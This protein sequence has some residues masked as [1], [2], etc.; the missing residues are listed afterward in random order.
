MGRELRRI[1]LGWDFPIGQTWTGY[2]N[3]HDGERKKCPRCAGS[4]ESVAMRLL[5]M[6]WYRHRHDEARA[7][8]VSALAGPYNLPRPL[9]RFVAGELEAGVGWSRRLDQRDV[10]ALAA[11]ERLWD[12][13]R[14]PRTEGQREV[15]REK[16][17]AG[18]NS[19]LPESNGY[20][21]TADEV[22][23]WSKRGLGHNAIN[24]WVCSKARAKRYGV[25]ARRCGSCRGTGV[26]PDADL[27]RKIRAW[28]PT[29][30]PAGPGYQIWQTVSEGG[31]V[32]PVFEK[33]EDLARWMVANDTSITRGTTFRGWMDFIL[34]PG[35]APA[36]IMTGGKMMSGVEAV[37]LDQ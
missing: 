30:P 25:I 34:G 20:R 2:L 17:A 1:A 7:F 5:S 10:D 21:P 16:V 23:A 13:T 29:E 31:P 8:I 6:V 18:G 37:R 3:P 12:F 15:V 35:W 27:A 26:V 11:A 19:W 24:A 36:M 22:N 9:L 14:V 32:S 28:R 4:G 33:P